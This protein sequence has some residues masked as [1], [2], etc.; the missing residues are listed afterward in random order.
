MTTKA[1][2]KLADLLQKRER[3]VATREVVEKFVAAYDHEKHAIQIPVRLETLNRTYKEF[4]SVQSEIE[5]LDKPE[6]F[7]AH[8]AVRC[9]FEDTFCEAKGF[10]LS[11]A[12]HHTAH[13]DTSLNSSFTHSQGPSTFH[14]RL[15]KIDLPKF[16]GDESRWISFRDNFVSMIHINEDIPVVNKLQYLLQSL[17]DPARKQFE[18]VEIQA[19]KYAPTWEELLKKYDNKRSLRKTLF[20]R[21]YELPSME[22]ESAQDLNTL[23]D[24]FQRHV[25][26][27]EKLGEPIN[28]WDT[29]LVFILSDKLDYATLRAWEQDSSKKEVVTYEELI[30]FLNNHVR[31]L[32]SFASDLQHRQTGNVKVAGASQKKSQ[33]IK[34][35]ANAAT[36][37]TRTYTPQCPSCSKQHLLYECPAFTKL[38][39]IQRRE[40]VTQR[41]L[42]WNCF[43]QNHQ[44]RACRSKFS[45]RICQAKHHT[46]LH[47]PGAP[48]H[49]QDAAVA[50]NSTAPQHNPPTTIG[51]FGLANSSET[52]LPIVAKQDTVLLETVNLLITDHHGRE[53]LV[54][55]LLDSASMSNFVSN[56]LADLLNIRRKNVDVTVAGLGESAKKIDQQITTTVKS[57]TSQ[58]ST[59]LDFLIMKPP[60]VNLPRSAV[61]IAH[62]N[63][64]DVRLADP[65]FHRPGAIDILIGG[66]FYHELHTGQRKPIGDGLPLL[67]ETHFGWT[68]TGKIPTKSDGASTLCCFST[69]A[70][71][72][73]VAPQP[74]LELEAAKP[75]ASHPTKQSSSTPTQTH[76]G[77]YVAFLP[78][79]KNPQVT[80]GNSR[81]SATHR[82]STHAS[83]RKKVPSTK[84]AKKARLSHMRKDNNTKPHCCFGYPLASS[85][86]QADLRSCFGQTSP[87][88]NGAGN[89]MIERQTEMQLTD[90]S[91][92]RTCR[93]V[94]SKSL[95]FFNQPHLR[96][97]AEAES[98]PAPRQKK[99]YKQHVYKGEVSTAGEGLQ[100]AEF[101]ESSKIGRAVRNMLNAKLECEQVSTVPFAPSPP[102]RSTGSF[103]VPDDARE[104][105][106]PP[107]RA[108]ET[109]K[110][111]RALRNCSMRIRNANW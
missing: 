102:V 59:T 100:K 91:P 93:A 88:V 50:S 85:F 90:K 31:M 68:V 28:Q 33:S 87:A 23:V 42:C 27:L 82:V 86:M 79:S 71:T 18:T 6:A 64:P 14:H 89:E 26:A 67:V 83:R 108:A 57:L 75:N 39:V 37:E 98:C 12:D 99:F 109:P 29:P 58:F 21:L 61:D 20:R 96:K 36:S 84:P 103:A 77:R 7:K 74:I 11:K 2:K 24:D 1:D 47:D 101:A 92:K 41:S 54:R 56:N 95:T 16:N 38:A 48:D 111:G 8:L 30:E 19:D 76:N 62:W 9:E 104:S 25:K 44:A 70:R 65:H 110:T 97:L 13:A 46:L 55:A 4:L 106:Q 49:T 94:P 17:E 107:P 22:G 81:E 3:L 45:C 15:P 72:L 69:T 34:F 40:L 63:M 5:Q 51:T 35:I 53:L 66:E 32:K 73:L 60:M 105:S 10:L 78:R 80:H 52:S 43:R